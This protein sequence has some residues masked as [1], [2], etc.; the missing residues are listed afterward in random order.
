[1]SPGSAPLIERFRSAR[2]DPAL[3]VL[4]GFHAIKH[5]LRFGARI[6]EIVVRD[7]A[8]VARLARSLAPDVADA[9]AGATVVDGGTFRRLAPRPPATGA[10]ALARRRIAA[11]ADVL[12]AEDPA[13]VVLL[14]EPARLGNLGAVVRVAAAAGAA[15]LVATGPHD[16]WHP[17]A[18][19]GAAGLQYAIPVARADVLPATDR[20]IVA[21]DPDGEP[22]GAR[23]LPG[24][25]ALAFG[26]ERRGLGGVL[27]ARAGRRVAI[28]M[29]EGVSSLNL[30]TAVAVV[31]Y[32]GVI[33]GGR[34]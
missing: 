7:P 20:P 14:E 18:I 9:L 26:N 16:P 3:A 8:G 6:E 17:D 24:R 34:R 15:G 1:M 29:R 31:L 28:P 27:L 12:A 30:A 33:G 5:A 25:V 32:A 13:P 19:R 23:P 11:A 21:V 2:A 4:E 22:L 10:I